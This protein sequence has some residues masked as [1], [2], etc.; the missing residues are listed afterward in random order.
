MAWYIIGIK[1]TEIIELISR[2]AISQNNV[3]ILTKETFKIYSLTT[4]KD[5]KTKK[6]RYL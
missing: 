6:S 2:K 4:D 5:K 1:Y 3:L